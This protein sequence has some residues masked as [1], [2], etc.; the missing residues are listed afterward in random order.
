VLTRSVSVL[1]LVGCLGAMQ[2]D[3]KQDEEACLVWDSGSTKSIES[4]LPLA[5]AL[6]AWR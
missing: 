1:V 3:L 5:I 6:G 4:L 2:Q